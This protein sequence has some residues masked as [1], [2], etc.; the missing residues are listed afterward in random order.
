MIKATKQEEQALLE[1][2][3]KS[4]REAMRQVYHQYLPEI[5]AFIR[6]NSGTEDDASDLFQ[7]AVIVLYRKL[8]TGDFHLTSTLGAYLISICRNQWYDRLK[9]HSYKKELRMEVIE[10]YDYEDPDQDTIAAIQESTRKSVFQ[11]AFLKLGDSCQKILSLFFQ[12]I[13]MKE[14]AVQLDTTEGYV[15]KR[16]SVCRDQLFTLIQNDP[17]YAELI[18]HE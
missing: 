18:S 12:K 13:P 16:K 8:Q 9:R 14:I 15:K 1:G 4:E 3:A 6:R 2:I 17:A 5:R 11:K 10:K 7:E